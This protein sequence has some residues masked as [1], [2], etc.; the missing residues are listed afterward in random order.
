M[1]RKTKKLT[2]ALMA[3]TLALAMTPVSVFAAED[4]T[5]PATGEIIGDG[6]LEGYVEEDAF[7]VI[8]P[9][10]TAADLA[11]VLDP[12]GLL[13]IG[14]DTEY[15]GAEKGK[16]A[17]TANEGEA[18]S[19]VIYATNKSSS[20]VRFDVDVTITNASPVAVTF[21]DS[22]DTVET[23]TTDALNV[24][25]A[26]VPEGAKIADT[27]SVTSAP[28]DT[29]AFAADASGKSSLSYIIDG[30]KDNYN[31]IKT[32]G[33]YS[34][35]IKDEIE[36]TTDWNTVGF[37]L[38]GACNS[39]A[40]WSDFDAAAKSD[41]TKETQKLTCKL[42]WTMTKATGD[43]VAYE[44]GD[45][46]GLVKEIEEE[47]EEVVVPVPATVANASYNN[48]AFWINTSSDNGATANDTGFFTDNSKLSNVKMAEGDG[49][50]KSVEYTLATDW[51]K[52]TWDQA[53][54]AGA[55]WNSTTYN[56]YT[57]T[58]TYDGV[59]YTA[60][61]NAGKTAQ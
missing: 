26:A 35:A 43:E 51:I 55:T 60:T 24:Y 58:F 38:T 61:C 31:I 57:L 25:F 52:I 2:A 19:K 45:T 48:S 50:A 49:E 44:N 59:E 53:S 15:S 6:N 5:D 22:E 41:S 4:T 12:Q 13:E 40:D 17:F 33:V 23:P 18:S 42:A 10:T 46:T 29:I 3:A 20:D 47:E 1:M 56:T 32:D 11:F 39:Q 30:K 36:D 16:I 7:C 37:T 8:L 21:V 14:E 28:S 54:A 34:Y 27:S 9:T